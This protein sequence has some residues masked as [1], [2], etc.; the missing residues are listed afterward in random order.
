MRASYVL[1]RIRVAEKGGP[2]KRYRALQRWRNDQNPRCSGPHGKPIRFL[3]SP[4]QDHDSTAYESLVEGLTFDFLLGDKAYD[5]N[6]ILADFEARNAEA[7]IPSCPSFRSIQKW[8][9]PQG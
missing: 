6:R 5:A 8:V 3:L 2:R 7:V 1:I 9:I 4:S